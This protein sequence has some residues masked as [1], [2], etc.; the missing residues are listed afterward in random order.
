MKKVLFPIMALVAIL[1]MASCSSK[2]EK[3]LSDYSDIV[4][5][6]T[7][8]CNDVNTQTDLQSAQEKA[9]NMINELGKKYD[10]DPS[11]IDGSDDKTW[12]E[13]LAKVGLDFS[14]DQFKQ[15]KE[16]CEKLIKALNDAQSR[17][18]EAA[19]KEV[20]EP[21]AEESLSDFGS[22]DFGSSDS[23]SEDWDALLDSYEQYV[24]EFI[25]FAQKAAN[26]DQGAISQYLELMR[27]AQEC[28]EKLRKAKD[29]MSIE[30]SQ[31]LNEINMKFLNAQAKQY[32]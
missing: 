4:N 27:K 17:I 5:E 12:R 13:S 18:E 14:D 15:F 2:E 19:A 6:V 11:D 20:A 31:R 10:F 1:M 22:S 23:G 30:Q 28:S 16:L 8:T 25:D 29:E 3:F 24:D 7:N 21:S 9:D 26:G 32:N